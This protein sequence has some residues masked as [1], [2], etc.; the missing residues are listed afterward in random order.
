[1]PLEKMYKK[2][3]RDPACD[4]C[5]KYGSKI[6]HAKEYLIKQGE[7]APGVFFRCNTCYQRIAQPEDYEELTLNEYKVYQVMDS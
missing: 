4:I 2:Y 1:M 3:V 6:L 5:G 7:L